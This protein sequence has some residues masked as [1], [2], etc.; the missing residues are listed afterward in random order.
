MKNILKITF[1][2][3][4]LFSF[5]SKAQLDTLNYLKQFEI[6]KVNYIG[7]PFSKL[8]SDMTQIQPKT[9]WNKPPHNNKTISLNTMFN[10]CNKNQSF[11]NTITLDIIWENPLVYI[12]TKNLSIQN[13]FYFTD[14]EKSFYGSK[15]I[16]DII[17]YR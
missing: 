4:L 2:L 16:K 11:Y 15:I 13:D 7:Q 14:A 8:L 1:L 5:Q 6:N 12:D 17:V 3:T 10:F 9:V